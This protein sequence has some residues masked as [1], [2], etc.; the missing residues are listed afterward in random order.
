MTTLSVTVPV[1][2]QP[3]STQD[4]VIV[5]AFTAIAAWANGNIDASNMGAPLTAAWTAYTPT[6]T[7]TSVNPT[8]GNGTL[9]GYYLKIGK[10]TFVRVYLATGSTTT[11]G[12]GQWL[13]ALPFMSRNDGTY[14][15]VAGT[16][17]PNSVAYPLT[18][19]VTSNSAVL[20]PWTAGSVV[21]SGQPGTWTV[22]SVLTIE[23]FYEAA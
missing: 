20:A 16:A 11:Q 4:P 18:A 21:E 12:S 19:V 10:L 22:G 9:N 17:I 15:A 23:G 6:W 5:N 7:A 13:F 14:Q 3:D 1:I 8:L 2:G